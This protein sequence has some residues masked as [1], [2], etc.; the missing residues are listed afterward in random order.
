MSD[1]ECGHIL[2]KSY[3]FFPHL[4]DKSG[5]NF[6]DLEEKDEQFMNITGGEVSTKG[7]LR[8]EWKYAV[9]LHD[10]LKVSSRDRL[11]RF[12]LAVS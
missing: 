4:L 2:D 10:I 8:E 1:C 11:S 7:E 5:V 3:D 12:L 6:V 9:Y